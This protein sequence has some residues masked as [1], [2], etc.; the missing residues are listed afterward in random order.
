M[1]MPQV[2]IGMVRQMDDL[3]GESIAPRRLN[4]VLV[5]AF[6]A[7]ALV[8]TA[9]GLYGVMSYLVTQRTR[10]IG[11]RMALGATRR[12][13]LGLILRQAGSMTLLGIG[14]G[15]AGALLLTRSMASMLFGVTAAN[16]LIYLSMSLL[17]ALVSLLAIAVPSNAR[18]AYRSPLGAS[19]FVA[20]SGVADR[21]ALD[22]VHQEQDDRDH[23]QDVEY[24]AQRIAGHQSQ[25][26]EQ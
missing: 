10:E 7:V 16:P 9:A 18:D 8:L 5:S 2:P 11:V 13:V 15:I 1:S 22:D 23:Q 4:F 12:E 14:I 21:P 20:I 3:I 19:R 24:A 26:P 25:E 6:A 17:L